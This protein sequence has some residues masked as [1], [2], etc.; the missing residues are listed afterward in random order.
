M[1]LFIPRWEIEE[2][3]QE[4]REAASDDVQIIVPPPLS[5][6]VCHKVLS[7]NGTEGGEGKRGHEETAVDRWTGFVWDKL[8]N[9][10]G[11]SELDSTRKSGQNSAGDD[12]GDL[13]CGATYDGSDETKRLSSDQEVASSQYIA[14][15]ADEEKSNLKSP[16]SDKIHTCM[17][18]GWEWYIDLPLQRE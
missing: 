10:K 8:S 17:G 16:F 18:L 14:Q 12:G 13:G 3:E 9:D 5:S 11:E 1:D 4:S 15:T 2:Q 6:S 7:D